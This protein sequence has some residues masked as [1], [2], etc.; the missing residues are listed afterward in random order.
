LQGDLEHQ[1]T[2]TAN[3]ERDSD[4]NRDKF[5]KSLEENKALKATNEELSAN[6]LKA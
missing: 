5:L 4:I 1:T 3:W 6:L 2:K